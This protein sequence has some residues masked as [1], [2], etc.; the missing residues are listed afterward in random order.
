MHV[1]PARATQSASSRQRVHGCGPY[2]TRAYLAGVK[3]HTSGHDADIQQSAPRD[4]GWTRRPLHLQD[5]RVR[6]LTHI[7]K[8][9]DCFGLLLVR[10]SC[11]CS[12]S[13]HIEPEALARLIGW[14]TTLKARAARLRC[15]KCGKKA[16]EVVAVAKPRPEASRRTRT[17]R[18]S[19]ADERRHP[20]FIRV[21]EVR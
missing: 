15:S 12:A 3:G 9:A 2:A 11:V 17:D 4:T 20:I 1:R 8:L 10:V 6:V 18:L 21:S 19:L 13:R 5:A 14:S 16:A 7:K